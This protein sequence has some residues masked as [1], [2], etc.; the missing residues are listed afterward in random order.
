MRQIEEQFNISAE[1]PKTQTFNRSLTEE[2]YD[3]IKKYGKFS[4]KSLVTRICSENC[5]VKNDKDYINCFNNCNLKLTAIKNITA[6]VFSEHM[7]KIS[8]YEKANQN[9]YL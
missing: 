5:F 1:N 9:P 2:E 6:N 8:S 7:E 3:S 4:Y